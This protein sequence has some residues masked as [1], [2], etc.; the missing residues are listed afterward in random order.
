MSNGLS[1]V[2]TAM[3]LEAARKRWPSAAMRSDCVVSVGI[4]SVYAT[5]RKGGGVRLS[6]PYVTDVVLDYSDPNF[7]T[8]IGVFL[9]HVHGRVYPS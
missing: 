9:D 6:V 1:D 8:M 5:V 3:V 7:E 4:M 2:I